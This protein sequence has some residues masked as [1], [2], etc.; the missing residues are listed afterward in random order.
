MTKLLRY[1]AATTT[2]CLILPKVLPHS[3]EGLPH[4]TASAGGKN[5]LTSSFRGNDRVVGEMKDLIYDLG[6]KR[7]EGIHAL[8]SENVAE[9][10]ITS[11]S[12]KFVLATEFFYGGVQLVDVVKKTFS[13]VVPSSDTFA[14]RGGLGVTY[15]HGHILVAGAGPLLEL[16]FEIYVYNPEGELVTACAPPSDVDEGFFNDFEVL[17]DVAYVTDSTQPR[18][19]NFNIPDA[20]AGNCNLTYI[21][22]NDVFDPI[23][24]NTTIESNGIVSVGDG[25]LIALFNSGGVYY[26]NP[27]T[28]F[29]AEAVPRG[30]F[31]RPDGLEL[32]TECDGTLTLYVTV[33]ES[34]NLFVYQVASEDGNEVP[35]V[36]FVDTIE[37]CEYDTP[38][39]SAVLGDQIYTANLRGDTVPLLESNEDN[40]DAFEERFTIV[41][42]C[43]H[44]GGMESG[45]EL[46]DDSGATTTMTGASLSAIG[47]GSIGD[48]ESTYFLEQV[49]DSGATTTMTVASLSA[50]VAGSILLTWM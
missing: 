32:V 24:Q 30:T 3:V 6:N 1:F 49:D 10:G 41:G 14:R 50:I 28:G 7:L 12:G 25:F 16:P 45:S 27:T 36:V 20:I 34:N 46:V 43:R 15:T 31:G 13:Y 33:G 11:G 5:P 39:T 35:M 18:L 29:T 17:D 44:V 38:A 26:F 9:L 48:M 21:E 42:V 4:P 22:L 23:V 8:T 40:L 2:A 37:S 47:V 19:W